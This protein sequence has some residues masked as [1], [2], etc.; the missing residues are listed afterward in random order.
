MNELQEQIVELQ[1]KVQFQ[2]DSLQKL[3]DVVIQQ[4]DV[5]QRLLQRMK[6]LEDKLEDLSVTSG[7]ESA[8]VDERPPHY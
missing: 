8:V 6:V 4:S 7:G 2:E 5:I 3:D 1:L